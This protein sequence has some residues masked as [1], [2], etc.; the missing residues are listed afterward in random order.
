MT[1][2]QCDK[3]LPT[4]SDF[5]VHGSLDEKAAC[6]R[7]LGKTKGEV[8]MLLEEN[9]LR[10]QEDFMWMGPAAFC[11]YID[12]M[13]DYI[14]SSYDRDEAWTYVRVCDFRLGDG[15]ADRMRPCATRVADSLDWV[16]K[17]MLAQEAEQAKLV[18]Q[19][20]DAYRRLADGEGRCRS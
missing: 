6:G 7:M 8:R 2:D 18:E 19:T 3:Q 9:F 20:R 15:M 10:Y 17:Q 16:A 11:Y 12:A 5:V 4:E 13:I 14:T 1:G